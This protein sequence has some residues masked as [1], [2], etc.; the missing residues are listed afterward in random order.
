[1]G[2]VSIKGKEWYLIR[3]IT[4]WNITTDIAV[5]NINGSLI[6]I[7]MSF[8]RALSRKC[9]NISIEATKELY[10]S[11]LQYPQYAFAVV[12]CMVDIL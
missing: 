5:V 12:K 6:S 10:L 1:M 2:F 3:V 7:S 9:T 8:P 11:L 4:Q